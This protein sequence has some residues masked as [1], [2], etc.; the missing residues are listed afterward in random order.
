MPLAIPLAWLQLKQDKFRLAIALLGV[1]FAVVLIFMQLGFQEALFSSAVRFHR[2]F[3]YDLALISPRT[4]FIVQP[5]SFSHR[6]LYQVAGVPEV[7]SIN[8]VYLGAMRWK[9]PIRPSESRLIFVVG[10]DPSRPG[11]SLPG[12]TRNSERIKRPDQVLFDRQSRPEYGPIAEMLEE[13]T[14]PGSGVATEIGNREVEIVGLYDLGT[15]F[16]IDGSVV[17]SDL[18]FLRLQPGSQPG[19]IQ[20]GLIKLEPGADV[21]KARSLI[22]EMLED[23][24]LVLTRDAFVQR[25]VNYWNTSTPIG[26]VFNFGVIV[27][28]AV[29]CIIVYQILFA[30]VS[31]HLQEYATLKAMGYSN[32]YLFG[33]VFQ[34]AILMALLGFL[35]GFL[36]ALLL[37]DVAGLATSLPLQMNAIR[38]FSVLSLTVLMCVIS[39]AFALRKVRS[40]DPADIY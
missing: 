12:V 8:G 34:E 11:L 15:S 22:D 3:E 27:G 10:F 14:T 18:N 19:L 35:P 4:D 31:D 24:V 30:D 26:Y 17:T 39:G 9:N 32:G 1:G 29:G 13:V 2:A 7:K 33:L 25:E 40:L 6:R 21:E 16:G 23:D 28:L 20:L 36:L 38:V 37:Y 5:D